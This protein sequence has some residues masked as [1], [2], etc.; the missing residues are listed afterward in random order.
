MQLSDKIKKAVGLLRFFPAPQAVMCSFGKDSMVMMDLIRK[1]LPRNPMS[2]SPFPIPVIYHRHPYFPAK[3]EFADKVIRSWGLEVYDCPPLACGVKSKEGMLELVARY[4]FGKDSAI[5]L[6]MNILDPIPRRDYVCGLQFLNRPKTIG[7]QFP[8]ETVFC[9]H[10]NSDVDPYD[11]AIPLKHDA[12]DVGDVSL[13]FPLRH[14][15]DEDI[16]NYIEENHVEYDKRRYA[17]RMEVPDKWLNP[18]YLHAC[19]KCIDPRTPTEE[20][21]CP[22]INQKVPNLGSKVLRLE[23]IPTYIQKEQY[24]ESNR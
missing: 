23:Q 3:N 24:A 11:G 18:D 12:A 2:A 19:T 20:V 13:V 8:C 22:K 4:P 9:G 6:P 5:D 17:G 7:I 1:N 15:T 14:W 21:V 16:W 10:K